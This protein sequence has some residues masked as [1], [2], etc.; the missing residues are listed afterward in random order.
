[1]CNAADIKLI[2]TKKK[3]SRRKIKKNKPWFSIELKRMRN[4]LLKLGRDLVNTCN[5]NVTRENF[6]KLKRKY[7]TAVCQ[8]K[9]TFK[10]SIY[11]KLENL[12]SVNPKEYWELFEQLKLDGNDKNTKCPINDD[13][14]I[15][16]YTKLL[17]PKNYEQF[18][19][20]EI[21]QKIEE[22]K[23]I[24][25][26]SE[27]DFEI[28]P[29]ELED[30]CKMLKNNKAVGIDQISNEMIKSAMP[31]I[32]EILRKIFNAVLCNKHYPYEWKKGVIVNLFKSGNANFTDNYRGLTINSCLAKVFNN[33]LNIRL[34]EFIE[35]N[36]IL[37]EV[38]IGFKKKAR[39]SDHLYIVNTIMRKF[40]HLKKK[41]F[42]CFVD[43]R[44]AYDSVWREALMYKLLGYDI[45]GN[46]FGVIEEMYKGG[47]ACIK[48]DGFLSEW[49]PCGRGVRQGDVL[50]P[51]LF[52]LY[53]NDI[54]NLFIDDNDSPVIGDKIIHCLLYADDLVLFSQTPDGLQEK[55]NKLDKYCKKWDLSVNTKKTE[56]MVLSNNVKNI[57]SEKFTIG[58]VQINYV[59]YYKYLGIELHNDCDMIPS[60]ENLCNR[61]WKAIFKVNTAYRGIDVDPSVKLKM[62]DKV[63]RPITCYNSEIWGCFNNLHKASNESQFWNR[64]EKLP[65]E[66]LQT[67]FC[68]N[69]LKVSKK[70]TKCAVMGEV[71]RFPIII[72]MVKSMLKFYKHIKDPKIERPLLDATYKEDS[73]LP[74]GLSWINNVKSILSIFD[75]RFNNSNIDW[76]ISQIMKKMKKSFLQTWHKNMGD[77]SDES[78]KLHILRKIKKSFQYEKYLSIV[79][80]SKY[81]RALTSLRI[82]SHKLEIETGR[83]A[84]KENGDKLDRSERFCNFCKEN[85]DE[86][87]GDEIH[88]VI[89]C[90]TFERE[91]N[92]LFQ[93]INEKIPLFVTLNDRNKL[94][95]LLSMENNLII[96][97]AKFIHKVLLVKR[98]TPGIIKTIGKKRKK[99]K[100]N[101]KTPRVIP[102]S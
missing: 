78:G 69:V 89:Q 72:Y 18:E 41:L 42:M 60:A 80:S 66:I 12:E 55:L 53:I 34:N 54:P 58:G 100:C 4:N 99:R 83:W 77:D 10:Q 23:K 87:V 86:T 7:K 61:S 52:N 98:E 33:I 32:S 6:F 64:A 102:I 68:T 59:N 25:N 73:K 91:R 90:K 94:L 101:K 82:A 20:D 70:S 75:V 5:N 76:T 40:K 47:E 15:N 84:R 44:K 63:V 16:H 45:K 30:A 22:L 39:T 24:P 79:K 81:R 19:I 71:G 48:N 26:F 17:G 38:Q 14:W 50:S 35:K 36:K 67:K 13:E 1:M 97:V 56:V 8:A 9:R 49:F 74:K 37:S 85:G 88:A 93:K 46:F 62:F 51:N 28:S 95:F 43:F 11:N 65:W 21:R 2:R 27:L 29:K 92:I 31:M 57:P 3:G 96:N